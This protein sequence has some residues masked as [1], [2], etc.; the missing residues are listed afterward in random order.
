VADA[1]GAAEAA[2][3]DTLRQAIAALR[4]GSIVGI[5][6]ETVYGLAVLPEAAPLATVIAAKGRAPEKGIAVL[7][8]DIEQVEDLVVLPPEARRLADRFWPGA[9]TLVLALRGGVHLPDTL[10]GRS[11]RLGIRLPDHPIPRWLARALGPIAVTSANRSG[12]PE[13]MTA[14]DLRDQLGEAVALVVDGGPVP[15]PGIPSTVVA[16]D[17]DGRLAILRSGAID[18]DLLHDVAAGRLDRTE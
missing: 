9:L 10:T 7:I 17:P 6:T 2:E 18:P 13:A 8:D 3:T 15:G 14:T 4:A 11:D 1:R 12:E 16:V 5:P